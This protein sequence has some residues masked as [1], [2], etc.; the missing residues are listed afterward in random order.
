[1]SAPLLRVE[2]LRKSFGDEVVLQDITFSVPEHTATVFIGSSG[3]G[4]ST[5]LRCI[6]LL[7]SIDDGVIKLDGLDISAVDIDPDEVR[8]KLGMVFQSFNLFPHMTVF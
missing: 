5:L 4:K 2:K 1:M 6:N 8:K 3:S 7:E